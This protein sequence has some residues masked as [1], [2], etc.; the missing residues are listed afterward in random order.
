MFTDDLQYLLFIHLSI[1]LFEHSPIY[2]IH[3]SIHS[4]T[5]LLIF[6][7]P[8]FCTFSYRESAVGLSKFIK[9][10][11]RSPLREAV[12]WIEYTQA[13]GGLPHLRP[14]VLDLPLYKIYFLDVLALFF[15]VI[16]FICFSL[17]GMFR[18]LNKKPSVITYLQT[19]KIPE[20]TE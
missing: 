13:M 20:K 14:K 10:L 12:D 8:L 7:C 19:E 18:W 3:P 1:H 6:F 5:D 4:F 11:P 9:L 15:L 17:K 2:L 16:A